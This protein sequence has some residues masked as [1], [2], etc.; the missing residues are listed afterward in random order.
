MTR[1]FLERNEILL[2]NL[3]DAI[4]S[5]NPARLDDAAHTYKDAVNHFW[6][7][8]LREVAFELEM[9]GKSGIMSGSK[10]LFAKLDRMAVRLVE[11]LNQFLREE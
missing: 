5:G 1:L 8:S 4:Y 9:K 3:E 10:E 7:E 6:A 11:E 2:R